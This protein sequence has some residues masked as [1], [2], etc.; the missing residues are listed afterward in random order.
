LATGLSLR[1]EDAMFETTIAGSLPKPSWLS[2]PEKLWASWRLQGDELAAG[3]R[4]ATILAVK[5]QEDCGIDIVCDGEQARQHFV[6]GFLERIEGIDF[7]NKVEMGI[8]NDRYKAMVPQVVAPLRLKG[9]VHAMEAKAARAHTKHKLKFTLPG[10]MTIVDTVADRYYGDKV[11]MAF[12][13]ADCLNTEA[14]ALEQDGIDVIQFDEP[15]F[16]VFMSEVTD[17]GIEALHRAS[18]GLSCK[19]AVHICYGY[20]IKANIDWKNSL[21]DEWRQYEEIFPA[22]AESRIDQ[23]SVECRN[24]RV[25]VSL[26]SLLKGKDVLVGVIDVAT[27]EIETPEDVAATIEQVMRYVPK[28]RIIACT[29]CGMAPMKRE[30]AEAKLQALGEGAGLARKR[31]G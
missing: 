9:R 26:L 16:N 29:N 3:K 14:R 22:L 4:D 23:V 19:T 13:F 2:E 5:L 25:P 7:T 10:P 27:D 12:A 17:W 31:F 11:K 20:G 6:H 24:S 15:A 28:E 1:S 8:R 21:G 30:I 18:A